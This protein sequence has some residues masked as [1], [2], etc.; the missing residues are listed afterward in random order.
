[1]AFVPSNLGHMLWDD[2][3]PWY[4]MILTFF[5]EN[6]NNKN[7]SIRPFWV[8]INN[9]PPWSTCDWIKQHE[10]PGH[11]LPR[12]Y[13]SR[14]YKNYKRWMDYIIGNNEV[15]ETNKFLKD[16]L[17]KKKLKSNIIC[18]KESAAG[19]GPL[20]EHCLSLHGWNKI[21]VKRQLK[22]EA[23]PC[24]A[25]RSYLYW[26]FR[27][28]MMNLAN[29]KDL[30]YKHTKELNILF[31]IRSSNRISFDFSQHYKYLKNEIDNIIFSA[32][33]E[34]L[35]NKYN[36]QN[37]KINLLQKNLATISAVEQI[38]LTRKTAIYITAAG[39]GAAT[40]QFLPIGSSI[41]LYHDSKSEQIHDGYVD[42][43]I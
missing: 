1:M 3:L 5:H 2:F 10:G 32:D 42:C 34:D 4:L 23:L 21:E 15:L 20:S 40:A 35:K 11:S 37:L 14:C 6:Y 13:S 16:D 36:L 12:G 19:L 31:S 26:N 39:G 7:I 33:N 18:Y 29:I 17:S 25:G 24:S 41:I 43:K 38:K 8:N 28:H 30:S 27:N 22:P 9:N